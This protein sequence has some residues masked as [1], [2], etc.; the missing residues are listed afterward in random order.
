MSR[1]NRMHPRNVF[2]HAP[3]YTDLAIKYSNFRRVCKLALNGK[4]IIDLKSEKTLRALTATLLQ[5]YFDL[6]V[7]FAPNSLIPTLPLRLNYIL[8]IEDILETLK[9][10]DIH[11]IDIG[12]GSSCIYTLL[13]AKK[14]NWKM[15]ALEANATNIEFA[16]ENVKNNNLEDLIRIVP[17]SDKNVILTDFLEANP[18]KTFDFCL[19]NPPFFDSNERNAKP[20]RNPEKRKEPKN[21]Q[22]GNADELYCEGGEVAFVERIVNESKK[23]P[24]RIKVFS[25][26]LG[27]KS[28]VGTI[29]D[30]LRSKDIL[31]F[32]STEFCQGNTTRW[33]IAW[34]LIEE[35]RNLSK[36]N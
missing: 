5:H 10:N 35:T 7:E 26:M 4:V 20:D 28:S 16:T 19:C 18:E 2:I 25:T 13:A 8:W 23:F 1:N 9:L 30:Y 22:T 21:C 33:G 24:E 27:H 14:N 32:I 12:C 6:K 31:N 36:V 11:G 3:D 17:Q 29:S 15:S 34:S